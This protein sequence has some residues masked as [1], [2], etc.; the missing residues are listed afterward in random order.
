M[1]FDAGGHSHRRRF[2]HRLCFQLEVY[3]CT[4]FILHFHLRSRNR[5]TKA[6]GNRS[7][8]LYSC[9]QARHTRNSPLAS[10]MIRLSS[11]SSRVTR[12][13]PWPKL[14]VGPSNLS[15]ELV[16]YNHRSSPLFPFCAGFSCIKSS[17]ATDAGACGTAAGVSYC[18]EGL[19]AS[20]IALSPSKG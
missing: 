17:R 19:M 12:T 6:F 1:I 3:F 9:R 20:P 15:A 8:T 11:A 5:W 4:A 2:A 18:P 14:L 10:V 7:R 13:P 16:H